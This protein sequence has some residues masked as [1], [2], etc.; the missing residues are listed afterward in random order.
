MMSGSG[1]SRE[2]LLESVTGMKPSSKGAGVVVGR[3]RVKKKRIEM[4]REVAAAVQTCLGTC[5]G[6]SL[7]MCV[8]SIM[9][10]SG[11]G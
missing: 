1:V 8:E 11:T 5:F 9:S 7:V 2:M 6:K 4:N 3:E 10:K